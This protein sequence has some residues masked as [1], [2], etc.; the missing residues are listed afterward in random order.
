[1]PGF[2]EPYG[3]AAC[4]DLEWGTSAVTPPRLSLEVIGHSWIGGHTY[5]LLDCAL[6][7]PTSDGIEVAR[8]SWRAARRL[9]QLRS[10]LH[11]P[12]KKE[13]G[14]SYKTFFNGAPFAHRL[15][16]TGTSARLNEWCSCLARCI[17]A[18]SAPPM[19]AAV[20]LRLLGA[21]DM[22]EH[23]EGPQSRW[24]ALRPQDAGVV[25]E[26][27]RGDPLAKSPQHTSAWS[28]RPFARP[29]RGRDAAAEAADAGID[30]PDDEVHTAFGL[31]SSR[32]GKA[33]T[34]GD[35]LILFGSAD[36]LDKR[37]VDTISTRTGSSVGYIQATE[38]SEGVGPSGVSDKGWEVCTAEAL[39]NDTQA[40]GDSSLYT[41]SDVGGTHPASDTGSDPGLSLC[42][43]DLEDWGGD[44]C[45]DRVDSRECPESAMSAKL[46]E[47]QEGDCCDRVQSRDCPESAMSAKLR[48]KQGSL[49]SDVFALGN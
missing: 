36:G 47:K 3:Y 28:S 31:V 6:T 12:V 11:D 14:D 23:K 45:C 34:A 26:A 41:G 18:R 44:G 48:G 35:A 20:T 43:E 24:R 19:V 7:L 46:R 16:P 9:V 5:Y 37:A 27:M 30:F 10:G 2:L 42:S 22:S 15:K 32:A 13:L 40:F 4:S 49:A 8:L 17:S 25:G 1:M 38:G 39:P 29:G 33:A 21:P